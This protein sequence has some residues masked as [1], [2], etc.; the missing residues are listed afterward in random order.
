[1]NRRAFIGG[2]IGGLAISAAV[3]WPFRVYSFPSRIL[4]PSEDVE[5][6]ELE[7]FS[8]DIPNLLINPVWERVPLF[9]TS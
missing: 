9:R 8:K 5:A 2:L 3:P 7:I 4:V 1:M 6:L